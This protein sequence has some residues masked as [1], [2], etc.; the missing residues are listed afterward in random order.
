[1]S[2]VKRCHHQFVSGRIFYVFSSR[3]GAANQRKEGL[4]ETEGEL[5]GSQRPS[6]HLRSFLEKP[7][8]R[9]GWRCW[10]D[11]FLKD[12]TLKTSQKLKYLRS[13]MKPNRLLFKPP[14]V[15]ISDLLQKSFT[16]DFTKHAT[17]CSSCLLWHS[18]SA[19]WDGGCPPCVIIPALAPLK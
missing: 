19:L 5:W 4:K 18:G 9:T 10:D 2:K 16:S 15:L 3:R 13:A 12:L 6:E 17:L 11:T 7:D 14:R 1:M 8:D